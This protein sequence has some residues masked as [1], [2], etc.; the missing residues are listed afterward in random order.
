QLDPLEEFALHVLVAEF[1]R[2]YLA[3]RDFARGCDR[4]AQDELSGE[5]RVFAKGAIVEGEDGALVAVEYEFDFFAAAR[6][7]AA[8][9]GAAGASGGFT[10][11]GYRAFDLRRGTRAKTRTA[12]VAAHSC[13]VDA[14]TGGT[15]FRGDHRAFV[16]RHFA[17]RGGQ[18]PVVGN[19][20]D[21]VVV[22]QCRQVLGKREQ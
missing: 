15:D 21:E 14:A 5:R 20:V 1:A 4:E 9:A 3:E 16:A 11:G 12:G 17:N 7:F 22:G 13:G 8:G 10:D 19:L 2:D 6:W 18:L